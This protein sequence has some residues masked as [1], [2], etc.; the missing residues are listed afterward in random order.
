MEP[1][2]GLEDLMQAGRGAYEAGLYLKA[3]DFYRQACRMAEQ[4]GGDRQRYYCL[5]KEGDA[6]KQGGEA[7]AA[8]PILLQAAQTISPEADPADVYNA[9][10]TLIDIA[11]F[12]KPA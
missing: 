10:V 11:I 1:G 6:L 7:E 3:A 8:L 9:T 5:R 4:K 2:G 12:R